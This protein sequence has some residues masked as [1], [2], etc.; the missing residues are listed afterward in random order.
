MGPRLEV[1]HAVK[2]TL[3]SETQNTV[4]GMVNIPKPQEIAEELQ[5]ENTRA[6]TTKLSMVLLMQI[7]VKNNAKVMLSA[8][9]IN[10]LE[11]MESNVKFGMV[12]LMVMESQVKSAFLRIP[13][14]LPLANG[15][16]VLSK[17]AH[18]ARTSDSLLP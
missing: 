17:K 4:A 16:R 9:H 12:T 3:N 18:G 14:L 1:S 10:T 6:K 2:K 13:S 11:V 15:L 7:N 8:K 5:T